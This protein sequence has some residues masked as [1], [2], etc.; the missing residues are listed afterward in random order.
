MAAPIFEEEF[1]SHRNNLLQ[2]QKIA[3][4]AGTAE[5]KGL[6]ATALKLYDNYLARVD[7]AAIIRGDFSTSI[8]ALNDYV[9]AAKK[10]EKEDSKFFSWRSN[11]A[12]SIIPEFVYRAADVTLR[13]LD[14]KPYYSK[15]DSVLEI[16][17]DPRGTG[18]RIIRKDQDFCVGFSKISVIE[19]G[20]EVT[21]VVPCVAVEI[22]TNID[23]NKINGLEYTAKRLKNSFPAARYLLVTETL[24]FSL[25]DNRASGPIDEVYVLR[26]QVRSRARVEGGKAPLQ[27]DV[28][29]HLVSD[30]VGAS[31]RSTQSAGHVYER[32]DKGRLIP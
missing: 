29:A 24:D 2:K 12:G 4:D 15:G 16:S 27:P 21:L 25:L 20:E 31:I 17:P 1:L 11:F 3:Q 23:I 8:A 10:I 13:K 14:L 26:K 30:I 32:L 18:F 22:K 28:F 7:Y 6:V 5:D 9:D 19:A